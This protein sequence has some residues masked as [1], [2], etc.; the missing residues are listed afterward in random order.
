MAESGR[1]DPASVSLCILPS[2]CLK[3][4]KSEKN[5]YMLLPSIGHG[6]NPNSTIM[7]THAVVF[8]VYVLVFSGVNWNKC[9]IAMSINTGK[10]PKA[11]HYRSL[12]H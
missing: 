4:V 10:E 9:M 3:N 11:G 5:P 7:D 2:R 12:S 6:C 1:E 8:S